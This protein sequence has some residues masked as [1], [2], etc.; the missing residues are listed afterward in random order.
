M[1]DGFSQELPAALVAHPARHSD[2]EIERQVILEFGSAS[3]EAMRNAA[4]QAAAKILENGRKI[5]V[6]IALME[7]DRLAR[8][9]PALQ[10]RDKSCAPRIP[11]RGVT[12]IVPAAFAH[13]APPWPGVHG[14]GHPP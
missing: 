9:G 12:V 11:R 6:C 1:G 14:G 2:M 13:R 5:M 4:G 7:E 10:L 8:P 3:R